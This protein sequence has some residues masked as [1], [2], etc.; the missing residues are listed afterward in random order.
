MEAPKMLN[1]IQLTLREGSLTLQK[2]IQT[3]GL[4]TPQ[5][6]AL[7]KEMLESEKAEKLIF[8]PQ[9]PVH[10]MRAEL[11]ETGFKWMEK[12]EYGL[13][14]YL[15]TFDSQ[16]LMYNQKPADKSF[17]PS[18]AQKIEKFVRD[19]QSNTMRI[20]MKPKG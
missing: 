5:L 11:T 3:Q 1:M 6:L 19:I 13:Q 4:S 7:I 2:P 18:F 14:E 12:S 17:I 10:T 9:G 15:Y 8:T 16:A 20:L